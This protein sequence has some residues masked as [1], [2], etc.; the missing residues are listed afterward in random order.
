M[1]KRAKED[2]Q[3]IVFPEGADRRVVEAA[4]TITDQGIARC[5]VL[6]SQAEVEAH[7]IALD[8]IEAIDPAVSPEAPRYAEKL[9]EL[10][11][12]KGMTLEQAAEQVK[13]VTTYGV[14]MVYFGDA[15]GMMSA[16]ASPAGR[17]STDETSSRGRRSSATTSGTL[18]IS[19]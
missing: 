18:T 3:T 7:G 5:V 14:M 15:D 1:S 6:G 17:R 8:G 12:K 9:A 4:R 13:D 2:V 11:A 19:R 10:R 16:P